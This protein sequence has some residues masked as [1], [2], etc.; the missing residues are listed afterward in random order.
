MVES[1][2]SRA[3]PASILAA[4]LIVAGIWRATRPDAIDGGDSSSFVFYATLCLQAFVFISAL[5]SGAA[6]ISGET[7][8]K[9]LQLARVKP[10][11]MWQLLLGRWL[12]LLAGHG[13]LLAL[14]FSLIC[15]LMPAPR[16]GAE[17]S[18]KVLPD[19]PPLAKQ[20]DEIVHQAEIDGETDPVKLREIRR[21]AFAR[22]PYA[23]VSINP[24]ESL[25][26]AFSL[27]HPLSE[28]D[29]IAARIAFSSDAYSAIPLRA[30][31]TLEDG[32]GRIGKPALIENISAR[33][34]EL[35]LDCSGF[36][37]ANSLGLV[38]RSESP[39]GS[40]PLMIQPRQAVALLIP[41]CGMRE[42]FARAFLCTMPV[43]ALVLAAGL[44]LG[45]LFSLPVAVFCA[46]C[47]MLSIFV[48]DYSASDPDFQDFRTESAKAGF[49]NH[50]SGV[51]SV[52]TVKTLGFIARTATAPAPAAKLS[53]REL[54]TSSEIASSICWNGVA[55]PLV[56]LSLAGLAL[57]RKELPQ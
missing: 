9:T 11:A 17:C 12:G 25:R 8:A 23:M 13:L 34:L 24:G 19:F 37:G 20:V 15:L 21:D 16:G 53:E 49:F 6:A 55:I 57:G 46:V 14:T 38:L 50:V 30:S 35:P 42:N 33:R 22:L 54:V 29:R 2:R 56:M 52:A 44:A 26:F 36:A 39:A 31:C 3:L 40:M 43:V 45:S 32:A 48:A 1:L 18:E 5:A 51:L 4:C 7:R 28:C 27:R 10:I 47:A 41:T